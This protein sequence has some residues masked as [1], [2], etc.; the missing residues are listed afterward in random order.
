M[1]IGCGGAGGDA[2]V[3]PHGGSAGCPGV[4][5]GGAAGEAQEVTS[6]ERE[7][8]AIMRVSELFET[9]LFCEATV[10]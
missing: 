7:D 5:G 3:V 10:R 9:L 8:N 4:G 1:E 6:S 2:R